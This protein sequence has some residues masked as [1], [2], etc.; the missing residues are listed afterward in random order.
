MVL[1]IRN[2][3]STVDSGRSN[4]M[5]AKNTQAPHHGVTSTYYLRVYDIVQ[6]ILC[7]GQSS[8]SIE[9]TASNRASTPI[10]VPTGSIKSSI[11]RGRSS[12]PCAE[13][14]AEKIN[15]KEARTHLVLAANKKGDVTL[16][17]ANKLA[18]G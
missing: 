3:P 2:L 1:F 17:L 9:P 6:S 5:N 15:G 4:V 8:G 13:R 10:E 18:D 12:K 14:I 7:E 11:V 16:S